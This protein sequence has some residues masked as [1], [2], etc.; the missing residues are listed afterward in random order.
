[1]GQFNNIIN[2]FDRPYIMCGDF[3]AHN[4]LCSHSKN[5]KRGK[6]LEKF[7]PTIVKV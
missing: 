4:T 1:M 6:A 5:N 3:N 2:Q 7:M